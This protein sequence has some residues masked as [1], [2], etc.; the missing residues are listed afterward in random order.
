MEIKGLELNYLGFKILWGWGWIFR[1]ALYNNSSHN[2]VENTS[3][4]AH[5]PALPTVILYEVAGSILPNHDL[6]KLASIIIILPQKWLRGEGRRANLLAM[7][8]RGQQS[9]LNT[10]T[11]ERV[12][13]K[14]FGKV[15]KTLSHN[16]SHNFVENTSNTPLQGE[17]YINSPVIVHE[18]PGPRKVIDLAT[19]ARGWRRMEALAQSCTVHYERNGILNNIFSVYR[20][21]FLGLRQ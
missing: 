15:V 1:G 9:S 14:I 13:N 7:Q 19:P 5:H 18:V 11:N 17:V 21:F 8:K 12:V 10:T 4:P 6:Y 20:W 3:S 2:F 16:S